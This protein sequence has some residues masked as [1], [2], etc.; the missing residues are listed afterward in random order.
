MLNV[1]SSSTETFVD[2]FC[3]QDTHA[4]CFRWYWY[5]RGIEVKLNGQRFDARGKP[6]N[7]KISLEQAAREYGY[8]R[9]EVEQLC[10]DGLV[11][12]TKLKEYV[13]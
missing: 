11:D 3:Q 13:E 9:D 8:D 10:V 12:R 6:V 7:R 4:Q 1:L 5:C 2:T